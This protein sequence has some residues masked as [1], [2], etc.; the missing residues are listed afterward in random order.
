MNHRPRYLI[1]PE[2]EPRLGKPVRMLI[3]FLMLVAA[4]FYFGVFAYYATED[5]PFYSS[6]RTDFGANP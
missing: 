5:D 4:L 2:S 3:Y 1:V 6:E